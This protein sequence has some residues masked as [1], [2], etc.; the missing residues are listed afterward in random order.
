MGTNGEVS[1]NN[2]RNRMTDFCILNNLRILNH[3]N[4]ITKK[5]TNT[6]E[7]KEAEMKNPS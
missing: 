3:I 4:K 7:E 2:N 6:L 1:R 5:Y